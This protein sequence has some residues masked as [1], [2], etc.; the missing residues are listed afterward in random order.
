M[1]YTMSDIWSLMSDEINRSEQKKDSSNMH[2]GQI[3]SSSQEGMLCELCGYV[4][5]SEHITE[6]IP[7]SVI[8]TKDGGKIY[9]DGPVIKSPKT[10][11]DEIVKEIIGKMQKNRFVINGE[12]VEY[13]PPAYIIRK[14]ATVF[15]HLTIEKCRKGDHRDQMIAALISFI[16]MNDGIYIGD[17]ILISSLNLKT[18][19]LSKGKTAIYQH[20][21]TCVSSGNYDDNIEGIYTFEDFDDPNNPIVVK[22]CVD[23]PSVICKNLILG[24]QYISSIIPNFCTERNVK[25]L[26]DLVDCLLRH[27]ICN[28]SHYVTLCVG[29]LWYMI[30]IVYYDFYSVLKKTDIDKE[31]GIQQNN[32][33][34]VVNGIKHQQE[35]LPSRFRTSRY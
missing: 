15:Y 6:S 2:C 13:Q 27:G 22:I 34:K 10:K 25:F 30:E 18:S 31:T 14:A 17:K 21:H 9:G 3:M 7:S 16:A 29:A 12:T 20:Y 35:S 26:Q 32:M 1:L 23:K 4:Y 28:D 19:G 11:I 8:Y 5:A 33:T 24:S